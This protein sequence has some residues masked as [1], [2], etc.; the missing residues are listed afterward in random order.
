[1]LFNFENAEMQIVESEDGI[2]LNGNLTMFSPHSMEPE[3]PM[4]LSLRRAAAGENSGQDGNSRSAPAATA[5]K[6]Y[7]VPFTGELNLSFTHTGEGRVQTGI[8]DFAGACLLMYDAGIMPAG[9]QRLTL[10]ASLP[11]GIYIVKLIT[12]ARSEQAVII[13]KGKKQ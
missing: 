12:A 4:Y 1:V 7:P 13:S 10:D 8:Y 2:S 3:R 9:E 6:A 5:L 11:A